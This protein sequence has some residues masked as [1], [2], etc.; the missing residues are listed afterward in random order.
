MCVPEQCLLGN[1]FDAQEWITTKEVE[2]SCCSCM[3]YY[4]LFNCFCFWQNSLELGFICNLN[5]FAKYT[6]L[7]ICR[8][9]V[10]E[11]NNLGGMNKQ[12]W[13][14]AVRALY[15]YFVSWQKCEHCSS[16]RGTGQSLHREC[17]CRLVIHTPTAACGCQKEQKNLSLQRGEK[18]SRSPNVPAALLHF[19]ETST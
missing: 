15:V 18:I 4:S 9:S 11:F 13:F 14:S 6:E 3:Q 2:V 17:S 7:Y 8:I 1:E 19:S 12:V 16:C 10:C 5:G